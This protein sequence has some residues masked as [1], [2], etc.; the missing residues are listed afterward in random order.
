LARFEVRLSRDALEDFAALRKVDQRR[1]IA[2]IEAELAQE[3]LDETRNRKRLRPNALAEWELRIGS[4][5]VF[6]DVDPETGVV[7]VVA[8]GR[9]LRDRLRIRGREWRL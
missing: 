5:R 9:K 8:C 6:Y 7:T 1:A 4:L 2:G 3:P